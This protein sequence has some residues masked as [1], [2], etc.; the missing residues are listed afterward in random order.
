MRGQ[1]KQGQRVA[2]AGPS[3]TELTGGGAWEGEG[4]FGLEGLTA[5]QE[6]GGGREDHEAEDSTRDLLA[7]TQPHARILRSTHLAASVWAE[8]G[9]MALQSTP[10]D[11]EAQRGWEPRQGHKAEPRAL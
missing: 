9:R 6:G 11:A 3:P 10:K 4:P 2:C 8:P 1:I 7:C 5:A